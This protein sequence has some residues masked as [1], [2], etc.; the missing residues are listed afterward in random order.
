MS[1]KESKQEETQ[2]VAVN[3]TTVNKRIKFS[4]EN[5]GDIEQLSRNNGLSVDIIVNAAII[6]LLDSDMSGLYVAIQKDAQARIDR[7]TDSL[8]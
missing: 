6:T 1:S 3:G 5:W 2:K 4:P 7:L 8:S